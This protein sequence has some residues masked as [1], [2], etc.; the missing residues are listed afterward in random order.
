MRRRTVCRPLLPRRSHATH[1]RP[2]N[3]LLQY[4]E[5]DDALAEEIHAQLVNI[6]Q[7][8]DN[9]DAYVVLF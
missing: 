4:G 3:S 6:R 7:Q 1:V 8:V 9:K 5:E 2:R